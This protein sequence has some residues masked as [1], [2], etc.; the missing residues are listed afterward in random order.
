MSDQGPEIASDRIERAL[1]RIEAAA[2]VVSRDRARLDDRHT[3]LRA[4]IGAAI[5]Q[6]DSL[7]AAQRDDD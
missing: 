5:A 1:A 2:A 7:I 6:L 3:A 4:Q